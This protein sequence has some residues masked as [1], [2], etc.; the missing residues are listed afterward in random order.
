MLVP[1]NAADWRGHSIICSVTSTNSGCGKM[2]HELRPKPDITT[3]RSQKGLWS[4]TFQ[5]SMQRYDTVHSWRV[6]RRERE[7]KKTHVHY[8]MNEKKK[9]FL[10]SQ[11]PGIASSALI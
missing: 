7:A 5:G 10:I 4:V 11:H 6:G 9:S 1:M 3:P 2:F 8:V